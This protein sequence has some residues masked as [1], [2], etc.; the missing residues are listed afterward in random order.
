MAMLAASSTTHALQI[1]SQFE[2]TL[3]IKIYDS[4]KSLSSH[5]ATLKLV[6]RLRKFNPHWPT[7]KLVLTKFLLQFWL[8]WE[9]LDDQV[10]IFQM[11]VQVWQVSLLSRS[12]WQD[13]RRIQPAKWHTEQLKKALLPFDKINL[14]VTLLIF[15]LNLSFDTTN[16][17][18]HSTLAM[19]R[20]NT[21]ER[22]SLHDHINNSN[23]LS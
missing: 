20:G 16:V 8:R 17:T 3:I 4:L 9:V 18:C 14:E 11:F 23:S 19:V 10:Q 13:S 2:F 22:F 6:K 15:M 5:H 7:E 21:L 12:N 1:S